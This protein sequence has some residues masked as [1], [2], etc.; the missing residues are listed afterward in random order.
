MT[1]LQKKLTLS[2]IAGVAA[3]GLSLGGTSAASAQSWTVNPPEGGTWSH[4]TAKFG[5]TTWEAWSNYYHATKTHRSSVKWSGRVLV[6]SANAAKGQTSKAWD[7]GSTSA[8]AYY[9]LV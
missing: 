2:I 1:G 3:I 8:Q 7:I 6:R 9:S 5:G 4:G